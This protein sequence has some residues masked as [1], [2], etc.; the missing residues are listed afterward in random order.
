MKE[1]VLSGEIFSW[2]CPHCK[3]TLHVHYDFLYHDMKRNYMIYYSPNGCDEINKTV[4]DMLGKF[5]GMRST[6]YRSVDNYNRLLEKIRIFEANLNDI[7]IEIA[8]VLMKFDKESKVPEGCEVFFDKYIDSVKNGVL[9]FRFMDPSGIRKEMAILD[10][11][12]Y[13]NYEETLGKD[14][15]FKMDSYCENINEKWVLEK[16]LKE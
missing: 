16:L 3:Q 8:K 15:Q 12:T 2:T 5:K 6:T 7:V 1:K 9:I 4:N 14:E 13:D 11:D 10:K